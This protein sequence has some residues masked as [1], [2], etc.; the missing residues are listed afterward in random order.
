MTKAKGVNVPLLILVLVIAAAIGAVL[1]GTDVF[2]LGSAIF[3]GH[4]AA[5]HC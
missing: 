1:I 4:H 3:C 2:G 5:A